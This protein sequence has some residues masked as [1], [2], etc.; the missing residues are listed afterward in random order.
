VRHLNSLKSN[1]FRIQPQEFEQWA[2]QLFH[3]QAKENKI[4]REYLHH[5][6]VQIDAIDR[7]DKVPFLPVRFFKKHR[8]SAYHFQEE[9]V[10]CSSTTTG[11][12]PSRHYIDDLAFY[13]KISLCAFEQFYGSIKDFH[14][15]GLLPSYLEREDASLVYM[16]DHFIKLSGSS[17]SGFYLHDH[18]KLLHAL[19]QAQQTK[20]KVLLIGVTFALLDFAEELAPDLNGVM[21]METG[22]MKG[23]R[24]ESTRDQVHAVLKSKLNVTN[25]HSEYGMTELLSQAYASNNGLFFTPPWMRIHIRQLHDP[26]SMAEDGKSG[27]INIIDLANM[28]SCAF[29]ETEDIGLR[30]PSGGFE[31]LGRIDNADVRGCSLMYV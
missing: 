30:K 5:L 19:R 11:S 22:G 1:V 9:K 17:L 15:F 25:I 12:Y 27:G 13:Q 3:F 16:V 21:V 24:E 23:R 8:I 6:P 28:H 10:F 20:R 18:R 29:I 31:V 7:L 26:F 14:V 2:L 4:Y